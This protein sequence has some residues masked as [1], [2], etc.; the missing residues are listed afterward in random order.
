MYTQSRYVRNYKCKQMT[1]CER[2]TSSH[3]G[4][5]SKTSNTEKNKKK[6]NENIRPLK[7]SVVCL[8]V[9]FW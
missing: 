6:T 8:F 7:I 4:S 1:I 2:L 3:V 5:K 9:C